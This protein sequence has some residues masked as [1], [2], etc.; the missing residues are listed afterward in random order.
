MG[1][2]HKNLCNTIDFTGTNPDLVW[3]NEVS[4]TVLQFLTVDYTG[5]SS[6]THTRTQVWQEV[7]V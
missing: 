2:Q 4:G 1:K 6:C 5:S 7:L 3:Y